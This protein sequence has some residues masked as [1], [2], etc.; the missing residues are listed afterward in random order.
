MNMKKFW[1]VFIS[2]FLSCIIFIPVGFVIWLLAAFIGLKTSIIIPVIV[3]IV[4]TLAGFISYYSARKK[5]NMPVIM[6]LG[7]A[8]FTFACFPIAENFYKNSYIPSIRVSQDNF[9]WGRYVPF[10]E[11]SMLVRLEEDPALKFTLEDQLPRI[12]GATALFPVYCSF[13]ENVFPKECSVNDFVGF[14]TTETAYEKLING[15][16]DIVFAAGPSRE[17]ILMAEEKGLE[18][19]FTPIGCEAFVF[20][21]NEKN[22]VSD[23]T[24]S[25]IRKIYSGEITNWKELGGRNQKIRPFQRKAGSGSQ[26]A[27]LK[28]FGDEKDLLP[29]ETHEVSDMMG[30]YQAVSDY[31]NHGNAIGYSFRFYIQK[32]DSKKKIKVLKLNGVEASIENILNKTY[33][34][35]DS[36]YAVTVKGKETENMKKFIDWILSSQGQEIVEKAGYVSIN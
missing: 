12:D 18:L 10:T 29:A 31:E 25:E 23:I 30:L 34:V 27:F 22:P 11:S 28:V 17:Q 26:T 33:P 13:V 14:S 2:V 5:F 19:D 20:I 7:S 24:V 9:Y 15:E 8:A 32:M 3:L 6:I 35:T 1:I 16:T 4:L 21:V 36:F